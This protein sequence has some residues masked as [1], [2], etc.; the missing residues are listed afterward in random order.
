M[1]PSTTG[2]NTCCTTLRLVFA[3][4][5]RTKITGTT[6]WQFRLAKLPSQQRVPA[7]AMSIIEYSRTLLVVWNVCSESFIGRLKQERW[8]EVWITLA[9][10]TCSRR[11]CRLFTSRILIINKSHEPLVKSIGH[12]VPTLL[13]AKSKRLSQSAVCPSPQTSHLINPT[14]TSGFTNTG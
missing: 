3:G 8:Y 11:K 13:F 7:I 14:P 2:A 4:W 1:E 10:R 6:L 9:R 12:S 5:S